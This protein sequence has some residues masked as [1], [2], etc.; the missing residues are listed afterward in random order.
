VLKF[1][2]SAAMQFLKTLFWVVLAVVMVLFASSN[3]KAVEVNLWAGLVAEIKLPILVLFAYLIGLV[4]TL[5]MYRARLWSL[6]RRL[7][8]QSGAVG[9]GPAPVPVAVPTPV[10]TSSAPTSLAKRPA[11]ER[12]ATDARAW[13][14]A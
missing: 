11:D 7:D 4:P 13:P 5:I 10:R 12:E 1:H 14:T 9:N 2:E 6:R 8:T 3:W